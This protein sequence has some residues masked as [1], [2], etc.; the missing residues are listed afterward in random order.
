MKSNP[1]DE[2]APGTIGLSDTPQPTEDDESTA[3]TVC[4]HCGHSNDFDV[5]R[6]AGC[7]APLDPFASTAPWEFGT[8]TSNFYH[9]PTDPRIKPVIF[10]GVWLYFGPSAI[11]SIW[12]LING[13][14]DLAQRNPALGFPGDEIATGL[15]TALYG[16]I[17][18]WAVWSVSSRYMRKY[19]EEQD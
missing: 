16:A 7:G 19:P 13:A 11:G 1:D 10:W 9:P 4:V 2:T 15:I 8:A 17:S 12:V 14:R 6:C 18:I 3:P 5:S